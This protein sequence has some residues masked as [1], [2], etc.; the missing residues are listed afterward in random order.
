[1][2]GE[3]P[4]D[5][6]SHVKPLDR[7]AGDMGF[8]R[9]TSQC[10]AVTRYAVRA[11]IITSSA[12]FRQSEYTTASAKQMH[13]HDGSMNLRKFQHCFYF[14]QTIHLIRIVQRRRRHS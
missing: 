11:P 7:S 2:T 6:G 4:I 12:Y 3:P 10:Q 14:V 8:A 5:D 9:S 1:M 13:S